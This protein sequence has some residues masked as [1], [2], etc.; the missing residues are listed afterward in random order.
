MLDILMPGRDGWS[1]LS[2]IKS[3][4]SLK[5]LPVIVISMLEDDQKAQG[6][7]ASAH[8][9]K[10]IDRSLL[11]S[12]IQ[13]LLGKNTSGM[14][15]LVIDDDAEARDLL[16]RLLSSSGFSVSMAENGKDGLEQ[17]NESLDLIILDL[18]MPVMDGFEFLTHFNATAM[19]DAPKI[20]IFSGMELDDTLRAT[21]ESVHVGFIDKN[22]SDLSEKLRQMAI[23][24]T[25][26]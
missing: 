15:A 4:D 5:H 23:S 6:L 9:T 17:L 2:E 10:P 12:Q 19:E 26:P 7:G 22:D 3:D 25:K 20:I 18:S 1:V 21:L 8:M 14:Q 24:A 13:S 16:A 11:L